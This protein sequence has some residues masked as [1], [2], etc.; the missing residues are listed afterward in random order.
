MQSISLAG[1]VLRV[2]TP[3]NDHWYGEIRNGSISDRFHYVSC[4]VVYIYIPLL[5][6][7]LFYQVLLPC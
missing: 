7:S 6:F 4:I 5:T 3:G 2:E 1:D